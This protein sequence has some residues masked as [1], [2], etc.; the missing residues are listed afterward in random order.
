MTDHKEEWPTGLCKTCYPDPNTQRIFN[1]G[2]VE[3]DPWGLPI[4]SA[5]WRPRCIEPTAKTD[6]VKDST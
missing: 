5:A 4:T 3:T 6:P 2:P 1:A